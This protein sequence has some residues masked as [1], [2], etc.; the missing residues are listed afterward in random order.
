[1]RGASR[2]LPAQKTG[3]HHEII[4]HDG[5]RV[6]PANVIEQDIN[7]TNPG[8]LLRCNLLHAQRMGHDVVLGSGTRIH[9]GATIRN[10]VIGSNVVVEKPISIENSVIFDN[11]RVDTGAGL[12]RVILTPDGL[13]DCQYFIDESKL[14]G[15]LRREVIAK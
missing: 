9:P 2:R 14:A 4:Y 5:N 6:R 1:M 7:L 3:K 13:V 8:D 11:T 15:A 12:D 10:S